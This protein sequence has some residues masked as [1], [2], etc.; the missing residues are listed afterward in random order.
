MAG[1]DYQQLRTFLE[2]AEFEF[3]LVAEGHDAIPIDRKASC[4]SVSSGD[5]T[6][7]GF[8]V[9]SVNRRPTDSSRGELSL[10]PKRTN[11][12]YFWTVLPTAL[13]R[14][15][16]AKALTNSPRSISQW[17][18]VFAQQG[19]VTRNR[20]FV[21]VALRHSASRRQIVNW[22]VTAAPSVRTHPVGGPPQFRLFCVREPFNRLVGLPFG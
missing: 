17:T 6:F 9:C 19:C 18:Q 2:K 7:Q 16:D 13:L 12:D 1:Q 21:V 14:R 8:Y 22:T 4:G 3:G 11:Q 10:R 5:G 20:S 15:P